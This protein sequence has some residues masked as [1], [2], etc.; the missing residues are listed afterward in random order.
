[1][2]D[3]PKFRSPNLGSSLAGQNCLSSLCPALP[4]QGH[5]DCRNSD[6][7]CIST[8]IQISDRNCSR[9][10]LHA[11]FRSC[12]DAI[13]CSQKLLT[14]EDPCVRVMNIKISQRWIPRPSFLK[15]TSAVAISASKAQVVHKWSF[16]R[17]ADGLASWWGFWRSN[18]TA[19]LLPHLR[20]DQLLFPRIRQWWPW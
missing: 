15:A 4:S 14:S 20:M 10:A 19:L 11:K 1:M 16:G 13:L 7:A 2:R 12:G 9:P 18:P 8:Y 17:W 5:L 3:G 6:E